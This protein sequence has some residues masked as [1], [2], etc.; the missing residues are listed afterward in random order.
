MEV[1]I[2][3]KWEPFKKAFLAQYFMDTAMEALRIEF[4]NLV[5][6]SMTAAQYEAKFTSLSRFVKAFV[7]TEEEK[8]K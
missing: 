8:A 7:A 4:I 3:K 6:R 2:E 1:N 5:Q